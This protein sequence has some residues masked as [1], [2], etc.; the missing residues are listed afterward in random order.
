M[1][2]LQ[3]TLP[4]GHYFDM[5]KKIL[6]RIAIITAV[7]LSLSSTGFGQDSLPR[8]KKHEVGIDI[9]NA[10]TFIKRNSQ[11]Y[12][13][14][15]RYNFNRKMSARLGLNL[16]LSNGESDGYYPDVKL[17]VQRNRRS[18]SWV[19]YYGLDLSYSYFKSNAVTTITSRVGASP[20]LGVQYFFNK[21]IS[22]STE[23]S[24]NYYHYFVTNTNTFDPVKHRDYFRIVIG[25]VGMVLISYHF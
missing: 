2:G 10:L 9:A 19:L 17:G 22:I 3:I 24:L 8:L 7:F 1:A 11:S 18:K 23:G 15:Y 21:R 20:F 16:D 13:L 25:S 6:S 5:R 4:T 12:L 14:N